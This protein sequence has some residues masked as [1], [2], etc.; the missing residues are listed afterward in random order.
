MR[1]YVG[2]KKL[3]KCKSTIVYLFYVLFAEFANG[4]DIIIDIT[5]KGGYFEHY[6]NKL[7]LK[8]YYNKIMYN[9]RSKKYFF[10]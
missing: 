7:Y 10:T 1:L 6:N 9:P 4:D 5:V 3:T 2:G 8:V